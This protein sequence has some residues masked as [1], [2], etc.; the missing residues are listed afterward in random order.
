MRET[1]RNKC[2]VL[3]AMG[4]KQI[5]LDKYR[6]KIDFHYLVAIQ[7]F[8]IPFNAILLDVILSF[9]MNLLKVQKV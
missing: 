4:T 1:A 6:D 2:P 3:P 9:Q 7:N 5:Y 8:T